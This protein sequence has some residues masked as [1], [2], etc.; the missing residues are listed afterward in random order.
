M[1]NFWQNLN[2]YVQLHYKYLLLK[3]PETKILLSDLQENTKN[4]SKKI[5]VVIAIVLATSNPNPA[6]AQLKIQ[7]TDTTIKIPATTIHSV[8]TISKKPL[9][10]VSVQAPK[11]DGDRIWVQKK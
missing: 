4:S 2:Y 10:V 11:F 5:A 7:A 3:I 9:K 8:E 1:K 6:L